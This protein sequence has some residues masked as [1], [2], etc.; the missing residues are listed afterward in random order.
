MTGKGLNDLQK[1]IVDTPLTPLKTLLDDPLRVLR[2]VRFAAR[3]HF[4]ISD[5]L[6]EAASDPSVKVALA[7]KVS[8]ER[9]G[10]EVNLMLQSRHPARA[11][12]LL[13][14]LGLITTVFPKPTVQKNDIQHYDFRHFKGA[15]HEG[16]S[17]LSTT[18]D[19]LVDCMTNRPGWCEAKRALEAGAVNGLGKKETLP[20]MEDEEARRLLWYAAFLKPLYDRT[21]SSKEEGGTERKKSRKSKERSAIQKLLVDE[22]KR[23]TKEAQSIEAI[24]KAAD[25]F[26]HLISNGE[27]ECALAILLSGAR[28]VVNKKQQLGIEEGEDRSM[29]RRIVCT[30]D[31]HPVNPTSEDDPL[32]EHAMDFRQ[33]SAKILKKVEYLW[34]AAF[35]LSMCEQLVD[36]Q[37]RQID[38]D[39][40]EL[41]DQVCEGTLREGWSQE[42]DE[43]VVCSILKKYDVFAAAMLQLGLIG[44]WKQNPILDGGEIKA[45]GEKT[46][47]I[48]PNLPN[49]PEFRSVMDAQ[50]QWMITH[51]GG[52]REALVE[53]IREEFP[54]YC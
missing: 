33:R 48:L 9:I 13:L 38:R 8:R 2:S 49:G 43:E 32:W 3:L 26:T 35:I 36:L 44:I 54:A 5:K 53:H 42:T 1:G 29:E 11:L 6:W 10:S 4:D 40:D 15:Y 14:N 41:A 34:R 12:E 16:L 7:R 19:H 25:E 37:T 51:P 18:H 22:L 28:V 47:P 31:H 17:L 24:M 45:G 39:D 20:L 52:S 23:P 21:K 30:M 46:D 27:S 50:I